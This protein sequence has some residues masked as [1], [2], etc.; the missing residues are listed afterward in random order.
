M[1]DYSTYQSPLKGRYAS[2]E[3]LELFSPQMRHSTWRRLW[4]ALAE[5]E[6]KLGLAISDEQI[7]ELTENLDN[8]DLNQLQNMKQNLSMMLWPTFMP[9]ATNAQ[10]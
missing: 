1:T 10:S 8:I 2:Q 6:K 3:M 7:Q 9:M 4:L 5:E